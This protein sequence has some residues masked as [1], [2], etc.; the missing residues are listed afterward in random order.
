MCEDSPLL[1]LA[2]AVACSS[3]LQSYFPLSRRRAVSWRLRAQGEGEDSSCRIPRRLTCTTTGGTEMPSAGAP[4]LCPTGTKSVR[5]RSL[6]RLRP[7]LPPPHPPQQP[8]PT[9]VPVIRSGCWG[10]N[11]PPT[12]R[13]SNARTNVWRC[14]TIPTSPKMT[15][16]NVRPIVLLRSIG[17]TK[18]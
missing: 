15:T 2:T 9:L 10:Y 12:P 4:P 3:S 14:N 8:I 16:R 11:P 5:R 6:G 18:Q 13:S 1:L 17:P 7:L